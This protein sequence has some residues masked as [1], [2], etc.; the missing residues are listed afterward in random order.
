L[1]S[2]I[3]F[4]TKWNLWKE[5]CQVRKNG[6]DFAEFGQDYHFPDFFTPR[7]K[8]KKKSWHRAKKLKNANHHLLAAPEV[9]E[10]S[11]LLIR[12]GFRGCQIYR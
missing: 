5:N 11:S 2:E 10:I 8:R 6:F 1:N 4:V 12:D 7:S 3:V 9:D